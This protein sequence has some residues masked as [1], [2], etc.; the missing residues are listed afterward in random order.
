MFSKGS[1][2]ESLPTATIVQRNADGTERE[3]RF[4]RRRFV[5]AVAEHI[6]LAQHVVAPGERLDIIATRHLGDPTQFWRLCDA[7]GVLRPDELE[8]VGLVIDVSMPKA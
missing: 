6:T 4:V 5:P 3:V 1:R 2:Y 7:N 8:Q